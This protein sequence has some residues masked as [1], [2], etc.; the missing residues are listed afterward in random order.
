MLRSQRQGFYRDWTEFKRLKGL[1][2]NIR[3]LHTSREA[4]S[5]EYHLFT[6]LVD[7]LTNVK[8]KFKPLKI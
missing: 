8:I 3:F 1:V 6:F 4:R 7:I 2:A 5:G